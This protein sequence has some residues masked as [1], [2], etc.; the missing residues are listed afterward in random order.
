MREHRES[1]A[2]PPTALAAILPVWAWPN[3]NTVSSIQQLGCWTGFLA[4]P[5]VGSGE[6]L[7]RLSPLH[8]MAI[9]RQSRYLAT[10]EPWR[11]YSSP[12]SGG[13]AGTLAQPQAPCRC[14]LAGARNPCWFLQAKFCEGSGH[15]EEC[16]SSQTSPQGTPY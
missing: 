7:T 11:Q 5:T 10:G 12:A 2:H 8:P 1:G 16:R 6:R 15:P 4:N 14:S 3:L 13:A 9:P